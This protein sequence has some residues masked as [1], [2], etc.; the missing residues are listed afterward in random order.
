VKVDYNELWFEGDV[1]GTGQVSVVHY[2]VDPE[3]PNCP[4]LK[5]SQTPKVD[6][7]PLT[8]QNP[9]N[10]QVEVQNVKNGTSID[11]PI[12][13]AYLANGTVAHGSDGHSV[14]INDDAPMMADINSVSISLSVEAK[15]ADIRTHQKPVT[16]LVSTV[17][18]SNCS[19]AHSSA[20]NSAM[21]CQ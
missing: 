12:F 14:N 4:C 7:D 1:D 21:G 3:G 16:T 17:R 13:T 15:Y 10:Y 11:D 5:R 18:L 20:T 9:E 2:K 6:G 8:G 19:Q